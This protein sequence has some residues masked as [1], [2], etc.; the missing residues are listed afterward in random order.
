M[1]FPSRSPVRV[2]AVADSDSYLKWS[3]ATLQALPSDWDRTQVIIDS[4]VRPSAAQIRSA[5]GERVDVL[6]RGRLLRRIR[7]EQPDVLLLACT[8]PVVA[9][10]T[11]SPRLRGP[12]RPVLLTGLPG[13]GVPAHRRT[14][15]LRSACDLM[16][17]HSRREIAE[18]AALRAASGLRIEFGLTTLPFLLSIPGRRPT[19]GRHRPA[20]RVTV[21]AA[22]ATVPAQRSQ[23]EQVLLV[24][25]GAGAIG[26]PAVVKLRGT[27]REVQTHRERWPYPQVA[28]DLMAAGRLD[29]GAV[30]FQTGALTEVLPTAAGLATVSSTAALEAVAAEVPILIISDFGVDADMINIVFEG[31]G[32]LGT[33]AD[34]ARGRFFRPDAGWSAA[35]YFHPV[36]EN[37]AL[38]WLRSLVSR[39]RAGNL[40]VLPY[41]GHRGWPAVRRRLRLLLPAP[42][43][44][45]AR[46]RLRRHQ[47]PARDH[48]A[49]VPR[50][51]RRLG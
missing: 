29:P 4:P 37:D 13:I 35:N 18:F 36:V 16:L 38:T 47:R 42:G 14:L 49:P 48:T 32:C 20:P 22:Q 3:A 44:A 40:S 11:D 21:F 30:T 41:R 15:E 46:W 26:H 19:G 1:A 17:L 2:L 8:G 28:A 43:R 51:D 10:L 39:R 6:R 31:S 25:A 12:G 34:L 7:R 27:G 24:L 33:L 23:R 50:P 9:A 5:T 45:V